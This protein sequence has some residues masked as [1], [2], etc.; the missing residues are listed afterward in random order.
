MRRKLGRLW[1]TGVPSFTALIPLAL[2][3]G[4]SGLV[5]VLFAF[6]MAV[7]LADFDGVV[8]FFL[9]PLSFVASTLNERTAPLILPSLMLVLVAWDRWLGWDAE[10]PSFK[11]SLTPRT[12]RL[13]TWVGCSC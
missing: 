9:A 13:R 5:V 4:L 11:K 8:S 12:R 10:G 2:Y 6:M 3:V 7:G 1:W